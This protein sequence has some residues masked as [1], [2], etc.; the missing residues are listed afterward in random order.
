M[1]KLHLFQLLEVLIIVNKIN[2]TFFIDK[3]GFDRDFE[4]QFYLFSK[5]PKFNM[6]LEKEVTEEQLNFKEITKSEIERDHDVQLTYK[7]Y[8]LSKCLSTLL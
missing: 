8:I 6:L 1:K 7:H 2:I 4:A 5:S 3:R